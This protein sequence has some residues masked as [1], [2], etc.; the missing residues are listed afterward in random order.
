MITDDTRDAG[1]N[2]SIPEE[3]AYFPFG[4]TRPE[5]THPNGGV[6]YKYTGQERDSEIGLYNDN[7]R[8]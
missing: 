8:L 6:N 5:S 2:V 7:A 1:G 4:N 3:A